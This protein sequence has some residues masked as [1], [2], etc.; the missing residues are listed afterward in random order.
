MK[1][2][3]FLQWAALAAAQTA[4]PVQGQTPDLAARVSL[5]PWPCTLRG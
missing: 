2:R 1:R 5:R 4:L 3:D